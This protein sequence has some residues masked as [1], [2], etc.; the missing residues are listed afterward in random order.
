MRLRYYQPH[1]KEQRG[2]PFKLLDYVELVEWTGR[3]IR[4]DKR[5]AIPEHIKP[6]FK[7]FNVNEEDWL[8]IIT[9]FNRHFISAAGSVNNMKDWAHST[10]RKW[11]ATHQTIQLYQ[12]VD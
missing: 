7:R 11:C 3:C 12:K 8:A 5:D 2:L 10:Q 9:D 4:E 6:I 1:S